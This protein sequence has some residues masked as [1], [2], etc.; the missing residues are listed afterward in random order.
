MSDP[1]TS[2]REAFVKMEDILGRLVL[3]I[4]TSAGERESNVKGQAGQMYTYVETDTVVLDGDVTDMIDEVPTVLEGFQFS[5]Q[6]VTG[7]LLP[8]LRK[9]G[10]YLGRVAQ[11]PSQYK[12]QMWVLAEPT[13]GDKAVAREY[14]A[15]RVPVNDPFASAE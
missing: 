4:P 12:T 11:K 7:Q 15:G 10:K 6:T 14:L 2:A 9:Q 13:E 5:G 1:F 3:V 8:T